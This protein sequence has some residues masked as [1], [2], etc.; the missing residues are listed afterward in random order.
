MCR[1]AGKGT[2]R[3]GRGGGAVVRVHALDGQ[4]VAFRVE[5]PLLQRYQTVI[6]EEQVQVLK[7]KVTTDYTK[8][9]LHFLNLSHFQVCAFLAQILAELLV[10]L[11]VIP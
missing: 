3:L 9:A 5:H 6:A 1:L 7:Q 2:L 8:L 11:L 4:R 10:L